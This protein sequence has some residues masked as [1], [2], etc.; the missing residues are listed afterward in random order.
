MCAKWF[1]G[2]AC[3]RSVLGPKFVWRG[4][5]K[6]NQPQPCLRYY[7][8]SLPVHLRIW[9]SSS[10]FREPAK[11][12]LRPVWISG[13]DC[14]CGCS[15]PQNCV[16][17]NLWNST[18]KLLPSYIEARATCEGVGLKFLAP[19]C[20]AFPCA[21]GFPKEPIARPFHF[22][23]NL[24]IWF[25]LR[26]WLV[27][28]DYYDWIRRPSANNIESMPFS[29]ICSWSHT[30]FCDHGY[31][32]II[33]DCGYKNTNTEAGSSL[34]TSSSAPPQ[35]WW[36]SV[37]GNS[38]FIAGFHQPSHFETWTTWTW[39]IWWSEFGLCGAFQPPPFPCMP[40]SIGMHGKKCVLGSRTTV[41]IQITTNPVLSGTAQ[42]PF[43]RDLLYQVVRTPE[44]ASND[45]LLPVDQKKRNCLTFCEI[46][47]N[48]SPKLDGG[49]AA[50]FVQAIHVARNLVHTSAMSI[51]SK[52]TFPIRCVL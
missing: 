39:H 4:Q 45:F 38:L 37:Y 28:S 18:S 41:D 26:V 40:L 10:S 14:Y 21:N 50:R 3:Q 7:E 22:P 11:S 43:A 31:Q 42:R 36:A 32:E 19:L 29:Q 1:H 35:S 48:L 9:M 44:S 23:P 34:C 30:S 16:M 6:R 15:W 13:I 51:G 17:S 8:F 24:C 49:L 20:C 46:Q 33:C 52:S 47:P 5:W 27:L 25:V 12:T 2:T